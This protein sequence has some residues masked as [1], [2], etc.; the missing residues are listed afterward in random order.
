V[1]YIADHCIG[2]V[3]LIFRP[4]IQ[5]KTDM[6]YLVYGQRYDCVGSSTRPNE[7]TGCYGLVRATNSSGQR[8]GS[9][10]PVQWIRASV[11]VVPY[12]GTEAHSSYQT[13]NSKSMATRFNLNKYRDK[14]SFH[15]LSV[16]K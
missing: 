11:E 3:R 2:D 7:T 14:Q 6:P 9:V 1:L 10:V 15:M 4:V 8:L 13:W 16:T 12:F 5:G